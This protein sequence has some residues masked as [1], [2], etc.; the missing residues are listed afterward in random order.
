MY[1]C[2][3]RLISSQMADSISPCVFMPISSVPQ[4]S[5]GRARGDQSGTAGLPSNSG[6]K[7]NTVQSR[8]SYHGAQRILKQKPLRSEA[9]R[10]RTFHRLKYQTQEQ[11]QESACFVPFDPYHP[12]NGGPV[13][14]KSV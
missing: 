10:A 4:F 13:I 2:S 9:N 11:K 1:S 12:N 3:K 5:I 6:I 7:T 8:L 14:S